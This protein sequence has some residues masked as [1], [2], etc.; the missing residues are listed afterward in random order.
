VEVIE[1]P[2]VACAAEKPWQRSTDVNANKIDLTQTSCMQFDRKF[3]PGTGE[4]VQT[5]SALA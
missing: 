4:S 2:E 3:F 1:A 5:D